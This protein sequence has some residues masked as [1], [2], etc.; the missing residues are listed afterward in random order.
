MHK[1]NLRTF[2]RACT[3]AAFISVGIGFSF[4]ALAIPVERELYVS[5][6]E[7]GNIFSVS[8]TKQVKILVSEAQILAATGAASA[9]FTDN[10]M[11][12]DQA[13]GKLYFTDSESD[14]ILVR[15]PSGAVSVVASAAQ[16]TAVTGE[17]ASPE[18]V[19]LTGGSLYVTDA[20]SDALLKVNPTTGAVSVHTTET[21]FETPAA[22]TG[23]VDLF[24][25]IAVS[26]DGR[27]IYV[28][29]D[30]TP[31]ALF[32]VDVASG[33]PTV[34]ATSALF[35]DLDGF[36]TL[37]PNGDV[38]ISNDTSGDNILRVT[39][40]GSV[41]EFLSES[42]IESLLGGEDAD[43][44]GGIA[45][46]EFGNFYLAEETTDSIYRWLVDD[47]LLGT[48]D[49]ASGEL[50]IS[51]FAVATALGI[52]PD[53][54]GIDLEGGIAFGTLPEPGAVA[55]FAIGLLGLGWARRYKARA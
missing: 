20:S 44:E 52:D 15:D 32:S 39:P 18:H 53:L 4:S 2:S 40:G 36:L 25:G 28:A 27:T 23:D 10:G 7:N 24:S 5:D 19:T 17:P 42:Q 43:L 51:E 11:F 1:N 50:F 22:I 31:N 13:N 54:V 37:A 33:A 55:L 34:L 38:I 8:P 6:S 14:S 29:S 9:R 26:P 41:S 30:D 16:I 12:F 47:P 49:T 21:A 46:D 3:I 45:F 35:T 48:I